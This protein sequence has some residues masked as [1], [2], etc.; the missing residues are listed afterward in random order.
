MKY[1]RPPNFRTLP[2]DGVIRLGPGERFRLAKGVLPNPT[3]E[4][5]RETLRALRGEFLGA[6]FEVENSLVLIWLADQF[7]TID[8]AYG[9]SE[10]LEAEARFRRNT[11]GQKCGAVR[12][13]LERELADDE[14]EQLIADLRELIVVRNVLAHQPCWIHPIWIPM[15]LTQTL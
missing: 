1:Q 3:A 2:M 8:P 4:K 13:I 12:R 15:L 7:S 6:T 10:F 5:W 9:G 14:A 11:L